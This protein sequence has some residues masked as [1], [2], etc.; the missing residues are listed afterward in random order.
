MRAEATEDHSQ[1]ILVMKLSE[2]RILSV[3]NANHQNPNHLKLY[4]NSKS[5]VFYRNRQT[6]LATTELKSA[7]YFSKILILILTF[8]NLS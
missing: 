6:F 2:Q 4:A 1:P 3:N 5:F 7:V 8:S